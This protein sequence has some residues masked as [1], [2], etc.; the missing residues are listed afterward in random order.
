MSTI[1]IMIGCNAIVRVVR[2]VRGDIDAN[3]NPGEQTVVETISQI[4]VLWEGIVR[5][6]GL[7]HTPHVFCIRCDALRVGVV[8]ICVLHSRPKHLVPEQLTDMGHTTGAHLNGFV[9]KQSCVEMSQ[10]VRMRGSTVVV[11][12]EDCLE[13]DHAIMVCLL[14]AS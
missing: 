10:E 7:L 11:T 12:W 4:N 14:N 6:I 3:L 13:V 2:I 1:G 9:R 5:T 8:W